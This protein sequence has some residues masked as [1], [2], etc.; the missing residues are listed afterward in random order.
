MNYLNEATALKKMLKYLS[1]GNRLQDWLETNK[2]YV[3]CAS[4]NIF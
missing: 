3:Q 4:T 1:I 2:V